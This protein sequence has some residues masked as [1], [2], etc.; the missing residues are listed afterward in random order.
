MSQNN[1]FN[2]F[3]LALKPAWLARAIERLLSLSRLATV[4][5]NRPNA[6]AEKPSDFVDEFLSHTLASLNC[7]W[8]IENPQ[9]LEKIPATGPVI[10]TANHPLGGIEGVAMTQMLKRVRPDVKVLTNELLARIPEF[11]EVFIG[12]D[13]LSKDA[14][15]KNMRGMRDVFKHIKQGGALLIYPA[16][17]VSAINTSNWRIED[18]EWNAVVGKLTQQYQATCVP[19]YIHGRNS[20]LFYL[21]GLIHRRLRTAL[22][23]R[24]L[25][26]AERHPATLTIGTP[27]HW[28]D[29]QELGDAESITRYL[30]TATDLMS[31]SESE[32][33]E[34][35]YHPPLETPARSDAQLQQ[36][37]E[38]VAALSDYH[39]LSYR[40]FDVFCAP[41]AKLGSIM[42][43]LAIARERTFRQA[44]E[45]TGLTEDSDKFDPHYLHLFVWDK[46]NT[47]I[48]GG[49][50]VGK[51][52]KIIAEHGV[53]GLYS[54]SLYHFD[55]DY[56]QRIG[57][58]LEVGRSFVALEY[59]R[60]PRALDLLWQGI[61]TWVVNNPSYHTLFGCV[62]ISSEHSFR[63]R[64]FLSDSLMH[65]YRAEQEFLNDVRPV[66][67]LKVKNKV[68]DSAVLKS[69][70]NI[71]LINKL[72]GQCDPGK[73]VPILLRQYLALN[74]RF[75]GF[76]VNHSFNQSLDGLIMVDLRKMPNKYLQRYLGKAGSESFL[77][78]WSSNCD[79]A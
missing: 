31:R 69:L 70:S 17:R 41:Y 64:A 63:A 57:G 39:L 52:D 10:I 21:A 12:V 36:L 13:V 42:P 56:I 24:E 76:T 59:Q 33:D 40:Q 23:P 79:A 25:A 6:E 53:D 50:R 29:I 19:M 37:Q 54:R 60:H 2:P 61:G 32:R 5:D 34:I 7:R 45:G 48:V 66:A 71:T 73:S 74:G 15:V 78:H 49:Y 46:D 43:E 67:P 9:A 18:S 26:N 68:W 77:N 16:G 20:R 51:T 62:S 8:Q 65:S 75:I 11:K 28:Q 30:R 47:A 4:Y 58:A 44:G 22:L 38:D 27:I 55:E 3:R 14:A 72:L 35:C 1:S